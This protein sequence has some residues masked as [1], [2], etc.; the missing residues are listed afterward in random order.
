M[1]PSAQT[2]KDIGI[3][4]TSKALLTH[5]NVKVWGVWACE[6]KR[7]VLMSFYVKLFFLDFTLRVASALNF[8]ECW[9]TTCL[10]AYV[11]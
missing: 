1:H 10:C 3:T 5:V 2:L 9:W 6:C 11:Q 7:S 4:M 8:T